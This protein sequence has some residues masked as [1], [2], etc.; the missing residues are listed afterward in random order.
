MRADTIIAGL[1]GLG[2]RHGFDGRDGFGELVA[3][4]TIAAVVELGLRVG[5]VVWA[6]VKASEVTVYPR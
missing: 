3:E 1:D 6:S 4:V 2:G 5:D